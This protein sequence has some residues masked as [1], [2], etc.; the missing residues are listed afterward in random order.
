MQRSAWFPL[1]AWARA[2][3][4]AVVTSADI[5][6]VPAGVLPHICLS[7]LQPAQQ[8]RE[9]EL[10]ESPQTPDN[11]LVFNDI[12]LAG[13]LWLKPTYRCFCHNKIQSRDITTEWGDHVDCGFVDASES[14]K[15]ALLIVHA[16]HA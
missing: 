9:K 14:Q 11:M 1:L 2:I 5:S 7:L 8:S 13:L 6:V 16:H 4:L 15:F 10:T 12:T 3:L